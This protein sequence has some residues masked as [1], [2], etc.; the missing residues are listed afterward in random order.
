LCCI[1]SYWYHHSPVLDCVGGHWFQSVPSS[2]LSSLA[3]SNWRC[4]QDSYKVPWHVLCDP[5]H[6]PVHGK[7]PNEGCPKQLSH[8]QPRLRI[9]A[10]MLAPLSVVIQA[11][12][13]SSNS[14]SAKATWKGFSKHIRSLNTLT[15]E[16]SQQ[17]C[18]E[19]SSS[20]KV[21]YLSLTTYL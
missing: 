6:C 17:L 8:G 15:A 19:W 21:S 7:Q 16:S 10:T 9:A 13:R 20:N 3:S 4:W 2:G 1:T 12:L 14:Q 11:I 5:C 18:S